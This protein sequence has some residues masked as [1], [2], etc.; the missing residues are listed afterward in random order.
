MSKIH[1][2]KEKEKHIDWAIAHEIQQMK[3]LILKE[4]QNKN[5]DK[6]HE[7]S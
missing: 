3:D 6:F 2:G 5:K 7:I 1:L 4:T